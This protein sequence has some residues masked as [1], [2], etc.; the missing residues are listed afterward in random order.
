[1]TNFGL[2]E[3]PENS[4]YG[5]LSKTKLRCLWQMLPVYDEHGNAGGLKRQ[6]IGGESVATDGVSVHVLR[7]R[8]YVFGA[9]EV[10]LP[11]TSFS[12]PSLVSAGLSLQAWKN[13][14]R[15][16]VKLFKP[17]TK[18]DDPD[19]LLKLKAPKPDIRSVDGRAFIAGQSGCY[20][21]KVSGGCVCVLARARARVCVCVCVCVCACL[22]EGAVACSFAPRSPCFYYTV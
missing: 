10:C 7:A 13:P 9:D 8:P 5:L 17:F 6:F 14:H 12:H 18:K 22:R 4:T 1:M 11:F 19:R 3:D 15:K 16:L 2:Y 21:E 20:S